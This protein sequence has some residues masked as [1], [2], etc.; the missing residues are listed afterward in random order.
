LV[1]LWYVQLI[2]KCSLC[3]CRKFG[4]TLD[5]HCFYPSCAQSALSGL[6]DRYG[7]R[8]AAAIQWQV[9]LYQSVGGEFIHTN[10]YEEII[11]TFYHFKNVII[12]VQI[13]DI[14]LGIFLLLCINL[15]TYDLCKKKVVLSPIVF[16]PFF[17][18]I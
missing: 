3:C 14:F 15:V 5:I 7:G 16:L 4:Q 13:L 17:F 10:R 1:K 2:V 12:A 11:Y 9:N 8:V 18:L 6:Y